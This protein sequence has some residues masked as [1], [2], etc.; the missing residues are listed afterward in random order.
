MKK[1]FVI[2]KLMC[3]QDGSGRTYWQV[4]RTCDTIKQA[5]TELEALQINPLHTFKISEEITL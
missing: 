2:K 1:Q 4:L 5:E 3:S